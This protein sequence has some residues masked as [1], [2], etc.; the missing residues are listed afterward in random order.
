MSIL[1]PRSRLQLN[2]KYLIRIMSHRIVQ[3]LSQRIMKY[4][5]IGLMI[6]LVKNYRRILKMRSKIVKRRFKRRF[7]RKQLMRLKMSLKKPRKKS[8]KKSYKRLLKNRL[9]PN[10]KKN[11][12]VNQVVHLSQ[13]ESPI[14]TPWMQLVKWSKKM[15]KK[16]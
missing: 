16:K 12:K 3:A 5:R 8:L 4:K 15:I 10:L 11:L 13:R 14:K 7:K 1:N 6:R 2:L 9:S